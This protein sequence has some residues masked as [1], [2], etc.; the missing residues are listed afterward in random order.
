M[1]KK[2]VVRKNVSRSSRPETDE[3]IIGSAAP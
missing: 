2:K 3:G 1:E